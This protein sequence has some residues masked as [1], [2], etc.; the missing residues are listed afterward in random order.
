M[1]RGR[2]R[3]PSRLRR[4]RPTLEPYARV[5]VVCE[6]AKAAPGYFRGLTDRFRLSTANVVVVGSGSDPR[7]LVKRA[8]KL[9]AAENRRGDRYD[10]VYCVFDRDKHEHFHT[11]SQEAQAAGMLLARS[12]PCFEF[13]LVLHFTYHRKPYARSGNRTAAQN[14]VRELTE[15][16]P[17]Y[18]KGMAGV[19]A[20]LQDRLETAKS[21]S[22]RGR[23]DA[24]A[25]GQDNP[26]TEVHSL[27]TY[28]QSLKTPRAGGTA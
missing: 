15:H 19:F 12:W 16:L 18:T 9:R 10:V 21:N 27:V 11:A 5:L 25:T 24:S 2:S 20:N 6:D 3:G 23:S 26:S 8:K 1:A 17:G 4:K 7:F 28:L 13:W 22:E 14:C